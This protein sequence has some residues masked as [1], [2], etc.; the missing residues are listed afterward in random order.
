MAY[1]HV[2]D[3]RPNPVGQLGGRE[4]LLCQGKHNLTNRPAV[5]PDKQSR[6]LVPAVGVQVRQDRVQMEIADK[7]RWDE[8][9]HDEAV[10][11]FR[12]MKV[13]M[14]LRAVMAG[15]KHV[16]LIKLTEPPNDVSFP[17]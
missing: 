7:D 4:R 15:S 11:P 13:A 16:M 6:R 17:R 10:R 2:F 3:Q 14:L 1:G 9:A 5:Q 8:P 12:H